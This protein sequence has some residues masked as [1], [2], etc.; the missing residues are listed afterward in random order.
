MNNTRKR[1]ERIAK[2]VYK[3][4]KAV[5]SKTGKT[6]AKNTYRVLRTVNKVR[7]EAYF[8][9]KVKATAFYNSLMN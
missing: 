3:Y 7:H 6:T 1:S 5:R 4:V 9:N 2:G 8:N